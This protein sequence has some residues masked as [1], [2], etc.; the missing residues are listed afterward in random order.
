MKI[1][2]PVECGGVAVASHDWIF[3]DVDGVVVIPAPIAEEV[4]ALALQKVAEET[5]V[6]Q[7]LE[8]GESLATVFARHNIL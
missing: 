2:V 7:E 5:T 1:D 8:A 4:I 6:R 3:G